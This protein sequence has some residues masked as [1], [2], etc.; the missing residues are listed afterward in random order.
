M[1]LLRRRRR[2]RRLLRRCLHD[3]RAWSLR[4][5]ASMHLNRAT[6]NDRAVATLT[7]EVDH[8]RCA[9]QRLLERQEKG[10]EDA[11]EEGLCSVCIRPA[12]RD[13]ARCGAGHLACSD[14]VDRECARL[15]DA[16]E[17]GTQLRCF[18]VHECAS[19]IEAKHVAASEHGMRFIFEHASHAT[20]SHVHALLNTSSRDSL[21]LRLS[22]MRHDGTYRAFACPRCRYGPLLHSRCSDLLE[23]HDRQARNACP[24][25]GHLAADVS[26]LIQWTGDISWD[27]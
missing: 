25:C 15:L 4:S 13:P 26:E 8:L 10:G 9:L 22:C 20:L 19:S 21:S 18:G 11:S 16:G 6:Q 14:C 23:H 12:G 5:V 24:R 2:F 17:R 27:A 3:W 1:W 7:S